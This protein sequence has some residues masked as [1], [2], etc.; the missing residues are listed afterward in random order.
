MLD[1]PEPIDLIDTEPV[2]EDLRQREPT[3]P[4]AWQNATIKGGGFVTGLTFSTA[5]PNLVFARTDVGGAYRFSVA[6][7]R[8][9]PLLDWVDQD[10]A[11]LL[12]VE[13]IALDPS[14]PE[15]VYLAAGT[16]LTAGD[17]FIL[18]SDDFGETWT[19]HAIGAAMGGNANGRSMGER[20]AVDP[21]QP[22][23]LYFGSR[24]RGLW[25]SEDAGESWQKNAAFSPLGDDGLG[26]SFVLPDGDESLYVGVAT[27]TEPTL[28]RSRDGGQSFEAIGGAPRGQMPHHAAVAGDGLVYLAY[29]DGPGPN[30]IR[31]GAV[32]RLDPRDD[33]WADISPR[34]AGFGGLAV[35]AQRPGTIMA[36]T[37]DLWAP[38]QIY[39]STDGGQH[40]FEISGPAK[41]DPAGADWL[42][43]GGN[44]LN[45][46]GWIGDLELDP[47]N[48][49]RA[50]YVTGQGIWW[51]D[52][53]TNTDAGQSA[54]F[55]FQNEGLEETVALDLSSP[56]SGPPLLSAL[57]DICGFRHDDLN[58]SPP[59][60]MFKNPRFGNTTSLD[61]AEQAPELVVRVGTGEAGRHGA[62]SLDGG[63]SFAAFES[64][65]AGNGAG[66]IAVSSD[67]QAWVW[68]PEGGA[69][70]RSLDRGQSWQ[71]CRGV[72]AG[73][74][75]SADR[76]N[77]D[78][79]FA[80]DRRG[81]YVS[82]DAGE[83]FALSPFELPRGARLHSVFGREGDFWI[84]SSAGLHR[85]LDAGATFTRLA[86]VN[87]ALAV[88]FGRPVR[89]D[90]YPAVY[91]SGKVDG[92][93]GLF[94]SDDAGES[95]LTISDDQHAFGWIGFIAGDRRSYGRVYLGTGGRG[96]VYG[97]PL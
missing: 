12:G 20:L 4:Y 26:I 42:Y 79:F 29:N 85:S 34:R 68:S 52:D 1:E 64:E 76:V 89:D 10:S 59:Q 27:L 23:R 84:S 54:S 28:Y 24:T 93:A 30:G 71:P 74:R 81:V 51:S 18:R 67:G 38:D 95:W 96:I 36:A 48:R 58:V 21:A 3:G 45:A 39:R 56:P 70:A 15:R 92:K 31:Q 80:I 78:L 88:G 43:F 37:I 83:S 97:D 82:R 44:E 53:V 25:T 55:V 8:W 7:Q 91:L 69:P 16:Y 90:A 40:W 73:A 6:E 17:G 77:Q 49:S 72:P 61:F 32:W 41:R 22:D 63:E 94:R 50:L 75:V 66:T 87:V 57:G 46:T 35:D 5:V 14:R 65:P 33:S 86:H 9:F 47:F 60:G 11:N 13:S 2:P 62:V 19:R